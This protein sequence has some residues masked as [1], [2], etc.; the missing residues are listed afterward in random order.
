MIK[1]VAYRWRW[2]KG[3]KFQLA[4]TEPRPL[5]KM[6]RLRPQP[7]VEPLY[8][9]ELMDYVIELECVIRFMCDKIRSAANDDDNVLRA[10]EHGEDTL[11]GIRT[12]QV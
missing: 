8:S 7:D 3:Q 4:H 1:P 6:G 10:F 12:E 9:K 5:Q 2:S 11:A